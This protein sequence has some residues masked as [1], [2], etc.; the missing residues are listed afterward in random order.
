M[1]RLILGHT[2]DDSIK[3][4]VRG[5]KRWPVAFVSVLDEQGKPA[6]VGQA[7]LQLNEDNFFTGV[8]KWCGLRADQRYKVKVAFGKTINTSPENRIRERYTNGHFSTFPLAATREPFTF[9]FGSCNLHS[10]GLL[11]WWLRND[12]AWKRV[13]QVGKE[14]H[15]RFM[16]HCGDQIYA[17]I[18]WWPSASVDHYRKKY[19]DAWED[20]VPAQAVLT[21]MPHY[22]ILDDHEITDD[23]DRSTSAAAGNGLLNA[24][25]KAYWEFQDQHNPDTP[26]LPRRYYYDFRCG[27]ARFFVMD[28]RF[29]RESKS[30]QMID[31]AQMSKL[32]QW[33]TS[34]RDDLKF[35]VTSVP[36]VGHV[37]SKRDR[38]DKW[39]GRAYRSQ[40]EEVL[41]HIFKH[42]VKGVV[43]LTGD[44][45]ASYCAKMDISDG[46]RQVS[47][48]ELMSS[49]INQFT[50]DSSLAELFE[51]PK[52]LTRGN[53]I[54]M[55]S[56][57]DP[58]SYYNHS[59]IMT[60]TVDDRQ[61][62]YAIH[63]TTWV[64]TG[65]SGAFTP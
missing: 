42:D 8:V 23:F 29:R 57:I 20:C 59:N 58:N 34:D 19:I 32:K 41:G 14:T 52:T 4:W 38:Q 33:L 27:S 48:H 40:R 24:A 18:P 47:V 3:I 39:S 64:E 2:T 37:R 44:M 15:A 54:T 65:P 13:S 61:V 60:V 1:P 35:V 11:E 45:H 5:T 25:L 46:T 50:P 16:L 36:F 63:R 17:D 26:G 28:T 62:S 55:T 10:M 7:A 53:G 31:I 51:S 43:F 6:G 56:T 30:K 49:P 9:L 22:M 12:E 21:E